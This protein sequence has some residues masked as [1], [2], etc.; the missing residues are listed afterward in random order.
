MKQAYV[1]TTTMTD[2]R[3]RIAGLLLVSLLVSACGGLFFYPEK[4]LLL[5]PADI[6]LDYRQLP[7]TTVDGVQLD[8]WLLPGKPP[9][10]GTVVYLHGNAQNISYHLASVHWLPQEHY[11]VYLYD[12]RGFGASQGKPTIENSIADFAAVMATLTEIIPQEQQKYIV[13]GQS[14]GGALAIAAVAKYKQIYPIDLLVVDSAFSGF[15]KIAR[16][17][18]ESVWLTKPFSSLLGLTV[19]N[20]PD[21]LRQ[22]ALISPTPVV[23]IQGMEDQIVPPHH[24]ERLFQAAKQPKEL[25]LQQN[26][27]HT[28]SLT[29]K[30]MRE[31]FVNLMVRN[32][33]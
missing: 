10:K 1:I 13:L 32:G 30:K 4:K 8:G 7:V 21:I 23:I 16:E 19:T 27:R 3:Y 33:K 6:N 12:Y 31:R 18:L 2:R 20:Q 25:W 26:A 5:T 9:V 15:R 22:I 29:H 14:L 24:A 11:N 28:Q 17:K